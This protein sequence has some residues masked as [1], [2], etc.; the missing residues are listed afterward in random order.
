MNDKNKDKSKAIRKEA[1]SEKNL[2]KLSTL[3]QSVPSG[4]CLGCT[5][6]CS[7]SVNVSFLEF[8]NIVEN[9]LSKLSETQ[10]HVLTK[11]VLSFYLL[12]WVKPQKC[13]FLDEDRK[14]VIYDVRPLPCRVFGTPTRDA[15][16]YNYKGIQ[17]QNIMAAKQ[18]KE[19]Y[20]YKVPNQIIFR[21]IDFCESFI[22]DKTLNKKAVDDL[23]SRLINMDGALYFEGLIDE[24]AM[25]GDLVSWTLNWLIE[26]LD[27]PTVITKEW[28]FN[29]KK[30]CLKAIQ[31]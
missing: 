21:K 7:E 13:P 28:L 8:A 12:E 5:A 19:L 1:L 9:G 24:T 22:P 18:I 29:L 16:E 25:N 3:Y 27:N 11:R 4:K 15:Y 6:C 20:G 17:R 31:K 2:N 30:D 14:C 10:L 23:S 26:G